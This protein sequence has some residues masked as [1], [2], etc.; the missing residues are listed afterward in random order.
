[1]LKYFFLSFFLLIVAIVAIAGFRGHHFS[2]PP[3]QLFDDMDDQ[4]KLK[5]QK[6]S[7]FFADMRAA[8]SPVD[9]TMPMGYDIPA[10]TYHQEVANRPEK[11][12]VTNFKTR[13]YTGGPDYLNT[14]RMGEVWGDGI[15]VEI[16]PELMARGQQRYNINCS[17][18]HGLAGHGNG[19]IGKFGM[20][21]IATYHDERMRNMP[22]GEIYNTITNGKGT[23]MAYGHQVS[24]YDRWA[25]IAYI[26]A[27]QVSQNVTMTELSPELQEQLKAQSTAATEEGETPSE[28]PAEESGDAPAESGEPTGSEEKGADDD[29]APASDEAADASDDA[30]QKNE[31][32]AAG[33]ATE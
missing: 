4:A 18:C 31:E 8:R 25:I 11:I 33:D 21:A 27:L 12:R 1:M 30:N 19:I 16:T 28:T 24:L 3:I 23:M 9:G 10:E 17:V 32:S 13:E 29:A 15:P 2:E 14:G 26:R 20:V 7:E 6:P 5:S 22:D